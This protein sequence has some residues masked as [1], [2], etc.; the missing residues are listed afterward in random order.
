MTAHPHALQAYIGEDGK[1]VFQVNYSTWPYH[2]NLGLPL[3]EWCLISLEWRW[4]ALW[5]RWN[6]LGV[7]NI[8]NS[9]S[10]L[11]ARGYLLYHVRLYVVRLCRRWP[12]FPIRAC[13]ATLLS[14]WPWPDDRSIH[15]PHP[16]SAFDDIEDVPSLS[17]WDAR[18]RPNRLGAFISDC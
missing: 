11:H 15:Q 7:S 4:I 3:M 16:P 9:R 10:L 18:L 6:A 1:Q 13:A 14:L 2:G 12:Q 17:V 5:F 8:N